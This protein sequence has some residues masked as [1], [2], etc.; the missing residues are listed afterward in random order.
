MLSFWEKQYWI[1]NGHTAVIGSGIVGLSTAIALKRKFPENKVTIIEK[2]ILPTGASTKNAGFACFGTV[3]ETIDDLNNAEESEIINTIKQRWQ[4]LKLL[5]E[6]VSLKSMSYQNNGGFEVFDNAES[7]EKCYES[8]EYVNKLMLEATG[9]QNCITVKKHSIGNH[10]H[11]NALFNP[12]ESQLNP[13]KLVKSLIQKAENLGINIVTGIGVKSFE[14]VKNKVKLVL[15][16]G[17]EVSFQKLVFCT[18][19]F[20]KNLFP[21]L[22]IIPARNQVILTKSMDSIPLKGTFHMDKGYI[23]FRNI[24]D[25]ILIGGARNLDSQNEK[26][27]EFGQNTYIQSYLKDF[28]ETKILQKEV[29]IEFEWSGIIAIGKSKKPI[30]EQI[31]DRTYIAA[32]LGGMGVAVGSFVADKLASIFK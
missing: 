23:Y 12:H 27:S 10:L 8:L 26:T 2:G 6:N 16:N 31:S 24:E 20:T 19:A 25:R 3:G 28:L 11:K 14:E 9:I 13:V 32:R 30:V 7:F 4:G 17:I 5:K 18:N 1:D 15:D 22:D 29:Q 21:N